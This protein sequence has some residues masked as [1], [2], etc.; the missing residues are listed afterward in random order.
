MSTASTQLSTNPQSQRPPASQAQRT[1]E[2]KQAFN[3]HLSSVGAS[4]DSEFQ[5]RATNIHQ[6]A[7]ALDKQETNLQKETVKLR[8]Q[9]DEMQKLVEKTTRDLHAVGD[10]DTLQSDL[11]RELS[12]LED[13]MRT[14]ERGDEDDY[15][16]FA[17]GAST[18]VRP[19]S[20]EIAQ[21]QV[22]P[23]NERPN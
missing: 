16:D 10:L 11:D 13:M 1:A 5:A 18:D 23:S 20:Q 17:A 9:G 6:N 15:E 14:V 22:D 21:S 12:I 7:K 3:S 2:A 8:K 19:T 4:L